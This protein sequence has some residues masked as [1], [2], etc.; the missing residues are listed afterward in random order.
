L[1]LVSVSV[2]PLL[3]AL[4]IRQQQRTGVL[5]ITAHATLDGKP[6]L[7]LSLSSTSGAPGT[8]GASGASGTSGAA[9]GSQVVAHLTAPCL[10]LALGPTA[11]RNLVAPS[12]AA[13]RSPFAAIK[14]VQVAIPASCAGAALPT[15]PI[16][17]LSP[18]SGASGS[19]GASGTSGPSGQSGAP[20]SS[21]AGGDSGAS[22]TS[23]ASGPSGPSGSSGPSGTSGSTTTPVRVPALPLA[24]CPRAIARL[25]LSP[26]QVVIRLHPPTSRAGEVQEAI[27]SAPI[28]SPSNVQVVTPRCS[29]KLTIWVN[30]STYQ[31]LKSVTTSASG[32]S[33][34]SSFEWLAPDPSN[35]AQ[36][37][38]PIPS[39]FAQVASPAAQLAPGRDWTV[40]G[41]MCW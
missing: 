24:G 1:G 16:T 5:S 39:G 34:T 31:P 25:R 33:S 2:P 13:A 19:S 15:G 9:G 38:S 20:G 3:V 23:G 12:I 40:T 32:E 30:P 36:L 4:L 11:I 28:P 29:D 35:L 8:S 21:G 18:P 22:G 10:D 27:P 7:E 37:S 17:S 41:A 14:R 26:G 6:A